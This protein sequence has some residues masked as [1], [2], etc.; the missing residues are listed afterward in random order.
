[1]IISYELSY[2]GNVKT[3]N[4]SLTVKCMLHRPT[5]SLFLVLEIA[6]FLEI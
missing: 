5:S 6:W 2:W 3:N 1:M 4:I